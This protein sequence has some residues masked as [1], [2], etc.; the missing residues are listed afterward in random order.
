MDYL[1]LGNTNLTISKIAIGCW[2]F[3]DR[4]MWGAQ[5]ET[6]SI[7]T[8]DAAF[9]AGIN[10]FE[11]AHGYG[12]GYAEE[13]LGKAVKNYRHQVIIATKFSV[14][15]DIEKDI[16]EKCE[17]SLHRLQTDYIDLLQ[18]HWP[19]HQVPAEETFQ[20]F[21]NLQKAGKIRAFGVSNY[22]VGDLSEILRYGEIASNQ[23]PYSLLFRAIEYEVQPLCAQENIGMLCYSTLLHGLLA[24]KFKT[25]ADVP[26]GRARTRHFSKNRSGT[27]HDE[28]GCETELFAAIE[29]IQQIAIEIG[30]PMALVS[31]AWV[32]QQARV[33]SAI[34]GART[35]EQIQQMAGAADL[36]LDPDVLKKLTNA[37]NQ[38]KQILGTNPDMWSSISR[39]R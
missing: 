18:I 17:L 35:P 34:V 14:T 33:A 9:E 7:A 25:A 26:D 15:G 30:Q 4:A 23:L 12:N 27:R 28:E 10:F 31:V 6:V 8:I 37:T 19:N 39:Y 36:K 21:A 38:V 1:K 29:Q 24:G 5:D 22:G 11:N 16:S 2:G 20:A 3:A 13:V 32:L